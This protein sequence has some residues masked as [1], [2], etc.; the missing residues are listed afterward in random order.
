MEKSSVSNRL[1][2]GVVENQNIGNLASELQ[3]ACLLKRTVE[4][5]LLLKITKAKVKLSHTYSNGWTRTK[6]PSWSTNQTVTGFVELS[7]QVRRSWE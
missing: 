4:S 6:K 3:R 1:T 7:I 2:N 5:P